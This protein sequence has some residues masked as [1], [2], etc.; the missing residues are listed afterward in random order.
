LLTSKSASYLGTVLAKPLLDV[1]D[2]RM[3]DHGRR[4]ECKCLAILHLNLHNVFTE[5][6][7]RS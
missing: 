3:R 6:Q 7:R 4:R 1:G 2:P 5:K